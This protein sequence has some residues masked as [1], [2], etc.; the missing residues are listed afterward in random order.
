MDEKYALHH[1]GTWMYYLGGNP[2]VGYLGKDIVPAADGRPMTRLQ[3]RDWWATD[4]EA[5]TITI[6]QPQSP[7]T[8]GFVLRNP[9]DETQRFPARL[10][11]DEY[12]RHSA[13]VD[14]LDDLYKSVVEDRPDEV[15][16][17]HGPWLR[18]DGT[19]PPDDGR[20]WVASLPNALRNRP[21]YQHLFPG[22]LSGL[23]AHIGDLAKKHPRVAHAFVHEQGKV[24][25]HLDIPFDQ[26]LTEYRPARNLDGS[27]SK[28]RRGK[29]V[30]RTVR[31]TITLSVPDRVRGENRAAAVA[32]WD[33]LTA[34]YQAELDA[35]DVVACSACEG[36]GY[37]P[38]AT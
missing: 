13:S 35:V 10:T 17:L 7:T 1:D 4:H 29:T 25:V 22:Y 6:T 27:V 24:D 37:I 19:P 21:E 32:E 8:T 9:A 33:R 18:L 28:S 2:D 38:T 16:T 26:P 12:N 34:Q 11:L 23:R 20:T 30:T 15:T 36:H 3:Q 5:A 14:V 31:R